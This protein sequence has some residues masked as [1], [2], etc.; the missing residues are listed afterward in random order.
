MLPYGDDYTQSEVNHSSGPRLL[1]RAASLHPQVLS[2]P[3]R[4]T[5]PIVIHAPPPQPIGAGL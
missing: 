2:G 5:F 1:L 3:C 4:K